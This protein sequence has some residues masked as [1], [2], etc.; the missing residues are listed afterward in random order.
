MF[1]SILNSQWKKLHR[2]FYICTGADVI[3]ASISNNSI[4]S[5]EVFFNHPI[6]QWYLFLREHENFML[7]IHWLSVI[8]SMVLVVLLVG[9]VIIIL[10]SVLKY[11]SMRAALKL[12][13]EI[14]FGI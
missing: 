1:L 4:M 5:E 14:I 7:Q 11:Y 13:D 8:N 12:E 9:F 3:Y 6:H 2:K 10:V